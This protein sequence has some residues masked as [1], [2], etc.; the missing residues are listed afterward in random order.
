MSYAL[1]QGTVLEEHDEVAA[2]VEIEEE[3]DFSDTDVFD[4][5][6]FSATIV[7][8][9]D[10]SDESF[11]DDSSSMS[12]VAEIL[13]DFEHEAQQELNPA[14]RVRRRIEALAERKRR[15]QDLMDFNDYEID[16]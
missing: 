5:S 8:E 10:D 14:R 4:S 11:L 3:D 7:L 9:D 2:E 13:A 12:G 16:V 15:H 1:E 6:D